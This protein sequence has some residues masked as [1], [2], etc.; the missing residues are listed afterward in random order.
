MRARWYGGYYVQF[1]HLSV[2]DA[3]IVQ[4]WAAT[5]AHIVVFVYCDQ[6]QLPVRHDGVR[7]DALELTLPCV[8]FQSRRRHATLS[9]TGDRLPAAWN[10]FHFLGDA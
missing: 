9:W 7:G 5:S 3:L 1:Q 4:Y 2:G 8:T 10:A 6:S